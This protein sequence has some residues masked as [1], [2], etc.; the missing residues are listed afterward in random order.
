MQ[1]PKGSECR[2]RNKG[3]DKVPIKYF[4]FTLPIKLILWG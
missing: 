2:F 1:V 4:D 3:S